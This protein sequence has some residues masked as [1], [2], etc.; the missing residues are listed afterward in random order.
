MSTVGRSGVGRRACDASMT[1]ITYASATTPRAPRS[2][3]PPWGP[4]ASS[5]LITTYVAADHLARG[6]TD[7]PSA[8]RCITRTPITRRARRLKK[9]V[10]TFAVS[11]TNN[12]A[13]A[14]RDAMKLTMH[15]PFSTSCK[16]EARHGRVSAHSHLS[17][18]RSRF[19][20]AGEQPG[21]EN[22]RLLDLRAGVRLTVTRMPERQ[23]LGAS[24]TC[25]G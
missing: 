23:S 19:I 13:L 6:R 11:A 18:S 10:D 7:T 1:T 15:S 9:A 4:T 17:S 3:K 24:V 20:R 2:S 12:Q 21:H 25:T 22:F 5:S 16:A 8:G 14:V